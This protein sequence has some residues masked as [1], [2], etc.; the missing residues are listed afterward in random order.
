MIAMHNV[1]KSYTSA[2]GTL[3]V[4]KDVSLQVQR[5]EFIAVMGPSGSGK[6]SLMHIIGLLDV[7]TQGQY[8]FRGKQIED[9]SAKDLAGLRNREIGFVFQNFHLL[10]RMTAIRNVE[11]PMMYAGVSQKVRRE[12]SKLLL[13]QVG[14]ANRLHHLPAALSGGQK[15]RV[16]IARALANQPSLL[17]ADEPTGALDSSTGQEIMRLFTDLNDQGVTVVVI[18]HDADVASF[19]ARTVKIQDGQIVSDK[20]DATP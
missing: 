2:S 17:L 11:L 10:P 12:K 9:F 13:E 5:G 1:T 20:G 6:S 14:L 8:K 18:T 7:P 4:L 16:A 19:A 3:T 15:Q